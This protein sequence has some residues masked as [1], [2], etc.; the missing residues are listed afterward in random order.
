MTDIVYVLGPGS[1]WGDREFY[2]SLSSVQK[3][4]HNFGRV[5]V[6]GKAPRCGS[7]GLTW[8]HVAVRDKHRWP[9]CNIND[10]FRQACLT[11][12][13]SDTFLRMDDD[14]FLSQPLRAD[15]VPNYSRG[16][17]RRHTRAWKTKTQNTYYRS[18]KETTL[19]LERQGLPLEDFEVHGPMLFNKRQ[20]K[21]VLDTLDPR[22]GYLMRSAYGNFYRVPPTPLQDCKFTT[23]VPRDRITQRVQARP[24]FSVGDKGLTQ[25]MRAT[26]NMLFD[27]RRIEG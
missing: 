14:V 6:V 26:L 27:C 10:C 15:A 7:P 11:E 24:F 12:E 4:L 25:T 22:V 16:N 5:F 8:T 21:A 1:K 9:A 19:W 17:L 20:L 23:V 18:L 3:Y 13:I 2:Y